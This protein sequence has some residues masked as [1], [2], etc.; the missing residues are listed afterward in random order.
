MSDLVELKNSGGS[1][2]N[3]VLNSLLWAARDYLTWAAPRSILA[4]RLLGSRQDKW[5]RHLSKLPV[6][7][8]TVQSSRQFRGR[9]ICP[10]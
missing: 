10:T 3:Q 9:E 5:R 1:R 7:Q 8:G 6:H 4:D 2:L